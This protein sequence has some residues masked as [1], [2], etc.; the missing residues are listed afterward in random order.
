[1]PRH[2]HGFGKVFAKAE[3]DIVCVNQLSEL[4]PAL[5]QLNLVEDGI[6]IN[7]SHSR[8]LSIIFGPSKHA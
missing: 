8:D 7:V 3:M 6:G 1:M 2:G 4:H 5:R